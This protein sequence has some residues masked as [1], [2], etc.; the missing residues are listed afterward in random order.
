MQRSI[1]TIGYEGAELSAFLD[2]LVLAEIEHL[3]DVRDVPVSRKRGFSKS[4]LGEALAATGISYTHLKALGDPKP[5]RDAMK[6]GDYATF[7]SIYSQHIASE[8][9][10][11]ALADAAAIARTSTT[12]L[13]CFER[14]PKHCHRTIVAE[15]LRARDALDVRHLG[16]NGVAPPPEKLAQIAGEAFGR[17]ARLSI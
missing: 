17:P 13:L 4:S 12:V 10:Q 3:V 1:F 14:N 16:I 2:T 9:A 5:G 6:R 15:E 7:L 11:R 8:A